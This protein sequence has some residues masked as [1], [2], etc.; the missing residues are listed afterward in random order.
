MSDVDTIQMEVGEWAEENFGTEQPSSYPLLGAGEEIGELIHSV[1][2]QKQGIRLD[3]EDV[4]TE[5]EKDAVGDIGVYLLDFLYREGFALNTASPIREH[6][7]GIVDEYD[8]EVEI[9]GE[10]YVTY[11]RLW[12]EYP[13]YREDSSLQYVV[14][15]F[16]LLDVFCEMRDG[17]NSFKECLELAWYGEVQEREWDADVEV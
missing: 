5:S 17:I 6:T 13:N 4:G 10:L 12:T 2:K 1:L 16:V 15:M 11:A 9:I 14:M 7:D 3:E 8:N